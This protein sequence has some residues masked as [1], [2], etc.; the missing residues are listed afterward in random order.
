M[1]IPKIK[2]VLQK[3]SIFKDYSSLLVSLGIILVAGIVFGVSLLMESS[4][5]KQIQDFSVSSLGN[6]VKSLSKS[7]VS[8]RQVEEEEKYQQAY[9]KDA[10]EIALFS[11][12]STKRELL[13][14]KVF[15]KP[16]DKSMMIFDEFGRAFQEKIDG[17]IIR[18]NGRNC[19]STIEIERS[20]ESSKIPL[21]QRRGATNIRSHSDQL[22]AQ[23]VLKD[24]MCRQ[25]AESALCYVY[26]SVLSGYEFWAQY[27]NT[28]GRDDAIKNCWYWQLGCWIT[29]D[30]IDT[31]GKMNLNSKNVYT[32]PVK[33]LSTLSFN[34]TG[35]L[36]SA[37]D[38]SDGS[39]VRPKY[40]TSVDDG[41][42]FPCTARIS[43]DEID[44]VHF[45][46]A[47]IVSNKAI[48]PFME[49][50]C[51]GKEHKFRG[52][53]GDDPEQTFK[54]NQ[55]TILDF[56]IEAINR[57]D[58]EHN[59]YRYG[60]DAVVKLILNCEYIFNKKAYDEIKPEV[61]KAP[62]KTVEG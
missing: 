12:Q 62:P 4:L 11:I 59:L 41:L 10:N 49:E 25:R 2:D 21:T 54:H 31:I 22:E 32:S 45:T 1:D 33:R 29:E 20:M 9:G 15:P 51:S 52:F 26:A 17:M 24:A 3:L 37:S 57:E 38:K 55:I 5:N 56:S 50:L 46:V 44:V 40:V 30:V 42:V 39:D 48:L 43:N 28:L 34:P 16:K 47:V 14:Y 61:I 18:I 35:I 6:K 36:M 58:A 53:S 27:K 7:V 60:E 19:P 13:S 23:I 8:S